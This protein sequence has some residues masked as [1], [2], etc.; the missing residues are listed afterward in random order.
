MIMGGMPYYLNLLDHAMTFRENIDNLFFRKKGEL[1]DEYRHLYYTLFENGDQYMKVVE[2][3]SEKGRGLTRKELG[4]KKD[5]PSKS[6]LSKILEDLLISGFVRV[7]PFYGHKKRDAVYQLCDYYS[8]FYFRFVKDHYGVDQSFWRNSYDSP[9]RRAWCGITFELLC[10]D[11]IGQIKQALGI[12]GVLTEQ[13][14][15][16]RIGEKME[17]EEKRGAQIDLI[18][19]RHDM[20]IN[21]CEIKFS[22]NE[23]EIDKDYDANLRNKT[24]VFRTATKTWKSLILTMVTTRGVKMNKY[25]GMVNKQVVLDDLFDVV[26][27]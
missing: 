1:W 10:K 17:N 21:V 14:G 7:E 18:I 25:S 6:S 8:L 9:A 2:T 13:Y 24:E 11:H 22:M 15:W 12:S 23:F 19:D 26:K 27:D 16:Y 4:E 5:F 3:L 20:A